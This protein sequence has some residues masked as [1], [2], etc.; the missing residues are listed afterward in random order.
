MKQGTASL[1]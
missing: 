1:I